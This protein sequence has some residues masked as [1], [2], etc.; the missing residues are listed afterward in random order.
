MDQNKI[1]AMLNWPRP[2]NVSDLRG[3]LGLTGYYRKFV[4]NY[5][6]IA[7]PLTDLLKKGKFGWPD[8]A[9]SVFTELKTAMTTTPTLAMPNFSEPFT[10]ESDASGNDIDAVLSQQGQPIAFMSRA[11]GPTKQSWSVYA[12]EMLAI[13][14]VIQTW[15][16]FLLGIKFYIQTDQCSLK[17]WLEQRIATP[18]QQKWVTKL[19]GYDYEITYKPGRDNN[20]ADALSRVS[21]SPS[22]DSLF[23]SHTSLW[24]TIKTEAH[25]NPYMMQISS[26][27][28]TNPGVLYSW[29]NGLVCYKNR[30]VV[31][32]HSPIIAQLLHEFHDSPNG[33]HSG[34]LRTYKRLTQQFYW[35]SMFHT[36]KTYVASYE[37]CQRTKNDTLSPAGLLQPLPIPCQVWD[38]ITMDFIDGLPPSAGKI[39]I[40]L[41]VDRLSKSAH[42]L[43]LSHPYTAKLVAETFIAS[44]A[45]LHGMPKSII[46][47]RDPVFISHFWREF[48]KMSGTQLKMSSAY[49][50]QTDRQT[51]VVNRCIEQYLHCF[52]YQQPR[53]WH[54]F[55]PWAEF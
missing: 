25:T 50:P 9:E 36:V 13:I 20:A 44:I 43:A 30:V 16:P 14:H 12:K 22:L 35:P 33:G 52:A 42:F 32:P 18:E 47:D 55:L 37:V 31:P 46:S 5:G 15:R 6:L 49:H 26:K 10:I 45:K 53:K 24:D 48:L 23:V 34:V 21:G 11:L 7:R 29:R 2:S 17:Y 41:V 19:L 39:A 3:F 4:R 51:E 8:V 54:C 28:I 1:T 38:D 27:A 40:L